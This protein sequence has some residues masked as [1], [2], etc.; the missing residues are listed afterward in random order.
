MLSQLWQV[1]RTLGQGVVGEQMFRA[2]L[3]WNFWPHNGKALYCHCTYTKKSWNLNLP[4]VSNFL[5]NPCRYGEHSSPFCVSV[6]DNCRRGD[7]ELSRRIHEAVERASLEVP[8]GSSSD[9]DED[10]GGD[11]SMSMSTSSSSL[12]TLCPQIP[13]M[14]SEPKTIPTVSNPNSVYRVSSIYEMQ[15]NLKPPKLVLWRWWW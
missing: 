1:S 6:V 3:R 11:N 14:N 10:G 5:L 4:S 7:G 15:D 8:S 9:E 12:S 2:V 13:P